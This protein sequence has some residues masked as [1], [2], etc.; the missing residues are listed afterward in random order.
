VAHC[1]RPAEMRGAIGPGGKTRIRR[2]RA[3]LFCA[4]LAVL[5]FAP[6]P[7]LAQD[8]SSTA[9]PAAQTTSATSSEPSATLAPVASAEL[10][11]LL[12][13]SSDLSQGYPAAS[14]GTLQGPAGPA[15]LLNGAVD[16]AEGYDTNAG[17]SLQGTSTGQPDTFTRG[18]GELGIHYGSRRLMLDAHYSLTGYYY[19]HFHSVDEL[20]NRLNLTA[21]AVL[22]PDHLFLNFNAFAAPTTLSR[23]GPLSANQVSPSNINNRNTYGYIAQPM[24][25]MRLGEYAIS[26]TSLSEDQ[27]NFT[28]PLPSNTSPTLPF[29]PAGNTTSTSAVEQISSGPYFGR[30][31]WDLTASY[32]DMQQTTQS[33]KD[34]QGTVDAAYAVDRVIAVLATAGYDQF[35]ASVPLTQSLSGPIAIGGF[36]YSFGPTF[37]LVA[38]AG[39]KN[40]FPTY[41]GSLHWDATA[42]FKIDGSLTDSIGTA[43]GNILNNL[44]GLALSAEGVFSYPQSNYWQT[45]GQALFPQFGTVSPIPTL[46]LALDNSIDHDRTAQ[47]AFVRQDPDQRTQYRL[48]FFSDT[49]NQL[50]VTTQTIPSTSSLYGASLGATHKL[51]RDLTGYAGVTY[52]VA[53]EFGGQDRII[54]AN[55]GLTYSMAKDLDCYVTGQYLQRESSGQIAGIVP[56]TDAVAVIGIRRM[57][58]S[59]D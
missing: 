11:S 9:G 5:A 34:S 55:A 37:S 7:A 42:M 16:L 41:L 43:Q 38:G 17:S 1:P 49:R 25:Q 6:F 28:Q 53:N 58:S 46:G 45:L 15:L 50:N 22:V 57:F 20:Q 35:K 13:N 51:R 44:S 30:F 10:P 52:S 8:D 47:L 48:S 59:G 23:V 21:K 31:K 24:F 32:T 18:I 4:L 39:V 40:N 12:N 29:V 36:R 27:V 56:L 26:Q 14:A 2:T 54:T 19:N 33:T 3:E